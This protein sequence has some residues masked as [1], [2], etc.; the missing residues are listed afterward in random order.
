MGKSN[1]YDRG[2]ELNLK[3]ILDLQYIGAMVSDDLSL[4]FTETFLFSIALSDIV[5]YH[6]RVLRVVVEITSIPVSLHYLTCSISRHQLMM[7]LIA[8]ILL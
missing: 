3:T 7:Y 1:L 8:Y 4:H 5:W 2:K 6:I